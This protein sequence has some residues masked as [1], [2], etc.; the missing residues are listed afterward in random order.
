MSFSSLL[1]GLKNT[2]ISHFLP[3]YFDPFIQIFF[4]FYFS[5][6]FVFWFFEKDNVNVD[7]M[8]KIN[9]FKN[10]TLKAECVEKKFE[11][12]WEDIEND[13]NTSWRYFFYVFCILKILRNIK[14][15]K[16]RLWKDMNLPNQ[17]IVS[18]SKILRYS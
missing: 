10:S 5:Y 11:F 4:I 15:S 13:A 17:E 12:F 16:S 2:L 18:P 9:N 6:C 3:L 14:G 7:L 8:E 1:L